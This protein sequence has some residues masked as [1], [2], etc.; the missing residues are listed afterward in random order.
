M[1]RSTVILTFFLSYLSFSFLQAQ[2]V[3]S[4]IIIRFANGVSA[5]DQQDFLD[6]YFATKIDEDAENNLLIQTPPLP[7]T[8]QDGQYILNMVDL[9]GAVDDDAEVDNTDFNY[10][11]TPN[12]LN[13]NDVLSYLNMPDYSPIDPACEST[14][15]GGSLVGCDCQPYSN[16]PSQP[17]KIGII[18]TG[19]DPNHGDLMSFVQYGIDVT[20]PDYDGTEPELEGHFPPHIYEQLIADQNGHGTSVAG[21]ITGLCDRVGLTSDDIGVVVFKAFADNGQGTLFNMKKALDA[22]A[23]FDLDILN[24]ST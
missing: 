21:I 17:I 2:Y 14:Y 10:L 15:P 24:L 22:A 4:E 9:I 8:T 20:H 7:F 23:S 18:D 19:V 5:Q 6:N 12:P 3:D 16:T 13:L 11:V 1:T